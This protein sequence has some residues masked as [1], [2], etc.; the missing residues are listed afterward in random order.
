MVTHLSAEQRRVLGVLIEKSLATPE[1]Y[2]MTMNAIIAACNQKSNRDPMVSY[3]EG[4]VGRVIYELQEMQLVGQADSAHG[5]RANRFEQ[6]VHQELGWNRRHRA[7]MAELLLR[8]PQTVGELRTRSARMV[9]LPDPAAVGSVLEELAGMEPSRVRV[10][11]RE[12]GRSAVRHDHTMYAPGE[13]QTETSGV[14]EYQEPTVAQRNP[15]S[16]LAT[17]VERLEA[18]VKE[19]RALLG[20]RRER[21][22]SQESG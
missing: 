16:S 17:R 20:D 14:R 10:L 9:P 6:R 13:K 3:T 11:P 15:T 4:D 18:E 12:P 2:P 21:N 19:L 5:A 1:Y 7:V 8:G 22:E